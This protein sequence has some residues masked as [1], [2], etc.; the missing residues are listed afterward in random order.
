MEHY[1]AEAK[2]LGLARY[3][4][5]NPC[6]RGHK[7]VWRYT[8][9]AIC[10]QCD[11]EVLAPRRRERKRTLYVPKPVMGACGHC[12]K[13]YEKTNNANRY[14]S[15]ECR[16][17]SK[18]DKRAADECWPWTGSC[19]GEGHGH[20]RLGDTRETSFTVNAHRLSF[21]MHSGVPLSEMT[22]KRWGDLFVCHT[23]DNP[24]CCNPRHLYLGTHYT[25]QRDRVDR[26]R[27]LSRTGYRKH[28]DS[29]NLV[30]QLRSK[31]LSQMEIAAKT[32]INQN[33]ISAM[34]RGVYLDK[35]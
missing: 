9:N 31:G 11:N 35:K 8:S 17:W 26:G 5:D 29:V 4:S 7:N 28:K 6:P 12:D 33:T 18:V 20:F 14:C 23:C 1:R 32:G 24:P 25:N 21:E 27:P 15:M 10:V 30:L 16:F 19:G 2:I 22:P 3:K 13:K 34:C